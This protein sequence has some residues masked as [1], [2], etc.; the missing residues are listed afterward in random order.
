MPD[1]NIIEFSTFYKVPK[2]PRHDYTALTRLVST[3]NFHTQEWLPYGYFEYNTHFRL[4]KIPEK[5]LINALKRCG[6]YDIEVSRSDNFLT[7][8]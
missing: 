1:I 2:I 4:C 8:M 3:P 5:L 7:K 6:F